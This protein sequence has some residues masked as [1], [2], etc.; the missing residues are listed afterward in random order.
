[1]VISVVIKDVMLVRISSMKSL[2]SNV[3]LLVGNSKF[4]G[5]LLT[6]QRM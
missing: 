5:A 2:T 4:E 6:P 3:L 1:M